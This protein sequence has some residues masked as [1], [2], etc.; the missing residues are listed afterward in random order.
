MS[1]NV[2]KKGEGNVRLFL[3]DA[4]LPSATALARA[5]E[6]S[7]LDELK[8][9]LA[10]CEAEIDRHADELSKAYQN[11]QSAGREAAEADFED[12]RVEALTQLEAGIALAKTE[13][14]KA[15][16]DFEALSLELAHAALDT[17]VGDQVVY[18]EL[19]SAAIGKQ[20]SALSQSLVHSVT[21]SRGDFPDSRETDALAEKIKLAP[22]MIRVSD[23]VTPGSC[24]FQLS[25]GTVEFDLGQGWREISS[26]LQPDA[27]TN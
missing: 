6:R 5:A 21:V 17:L 9:K 23:E 12:S 24:S 2:I 3:K 22:G 8:H 13:L 26:I 4:E 15:L 10:Q 16:K 11:G 25:L 14:Q 7:P 27:G 1:A 18:K 20:S 19:L